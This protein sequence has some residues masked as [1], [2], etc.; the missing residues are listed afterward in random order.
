LR[1]LLK[2]FSQGNKKQWKKKLF[3]LIRTKEREKKNLIFFRIYK[4]FLG[5]K[6]MIDY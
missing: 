4:H 3:P 2:G 5:K 1:R 6:N